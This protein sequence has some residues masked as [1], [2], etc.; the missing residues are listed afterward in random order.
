MGEAQSAEAVR[1]GGQSW[2]F[3]HEARP[4]SGGEAELAVLCHAPR[5]GY[6][7]HTRPDQIGGGVRTG[8][9][10]GGARPHA[11]PA[12]GL[13][14]VGLFGAGGGDAADGVTAA[15]SGHDLIASKKW[16]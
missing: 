15:G 6:V 13:A 1:N 16:Q 9:C 7:P 11:K 12:V 2:L 4:A 8:V 10:R 5:I 14:L 3:P